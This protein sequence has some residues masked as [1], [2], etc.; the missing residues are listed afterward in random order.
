[1]D[2]YIICDNGHHRPM[3]DDEMAYWQA[4][5]AETEKQIAEHVSAIDNITA[6]KKSARTKLAE[7]G[8]ND[9]EINALIS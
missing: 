9:N 8:L 7:L 1:M 5:A 6:A 2:N 3:T 4:N